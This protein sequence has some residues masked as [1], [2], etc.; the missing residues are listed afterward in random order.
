MLDHKHHLHRDVC[1]EIFDSFDDP[2]LHPGVSLQPL[3]GCRRMPSSKHH[4]HP[5]LAAIAA[6]FEQPDL[7]EPR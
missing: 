7:A 3:A 4:L 5:E 2:D 1:Q 6:R